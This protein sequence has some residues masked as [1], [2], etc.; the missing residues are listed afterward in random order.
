MPRAHLQFRSVRSLGEFA[1]GQ[2]C[3]LYVV[4][5]QGNRTP[6]PGVISLMINVSARS[7]VATIT[8]VVDHIDADALELIE[9]TS[10]DSHALSIEQLIAEAR[11]DAGVEIGGD[12]HAWNTARAR[13]RRNLS[14]MADRLESA[15]R[16][17][18]DR[19]R[20]VI[21]EA[22]LRVAKAVAQSPDLASETRDINNAIDDAMRDLTES[23]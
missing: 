22:C 13:N 9:T 19:L 1:R 2:D 3:G 15:R 11:E 6:I 5:A 10:A 14:A 16:I 21:R 17:S 23:R 12:P 18:M 7:A 20:D 4:D 8:A